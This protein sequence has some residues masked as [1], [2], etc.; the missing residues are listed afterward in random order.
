MDSSKSIFLI[1]DP[2]HLIKTTRNCLL[3]SR[4]GGKRYMW[5]NGDLVWQDIIDLFSNI[6]KQSPNELVNLHKLSIEHIYPSSFQKM[7]VNLAAQVLSTSVALSVK[8]ISLKEF[9][10]IFDKFF[11]IC[12]STVNCKKSNSHPF[13]TVSDVRLDWLQNKFVAYLENWKIN[14]Q[15]RRKRDGT[16]FTSKEKK[17][18]TLSDETMDGCI[19]TAKS[20]IC[21]T[22]YMLNA[23]ARYVLLK[24]IS[25]DVLEGFFGRVR[26]QGGAN[27]QPN[28]PQFCQS[29][30]TLNTLRGIKRCFGKVGG[31][32]TENHN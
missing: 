8:S 13:F 4:P 20:L 25:Q 27:K 26:Q 31:N 2:S 15:D 3:K 17:I 28:V 21:I 23:G 14:V 6:S 11:D 30:H 12:N 24:R 10:L 18:M 22:K 9:I 7:R 29:M 16:E 5:N 32:V 1:S 19:I